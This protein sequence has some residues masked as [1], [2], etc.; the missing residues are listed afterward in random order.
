VPPGDGLGVGHPVERVVDLHRG[1]ALRVVRQHLAGGELLRIEGASPL[2][3][4]VA[5]RADTNHGDWPA[6][7]PPPAQS[8]ISGCP[9]RSSFPSVQAWFRVIGSGS[10]R[11][12]TDTVWT[13]A[14]S[15]PGRECY[16]MPGG[17]GFRPQRRL[18]MLTHVEIVL[19]A[20]VILVFAV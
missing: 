15:V 10:S 3:I 11:G 13:A 20:V 1:K 2:R 17:T 4:V 18:D 12:N 6:I 5:R 8:S 14:C 7:I 9:T 16:G 19:S